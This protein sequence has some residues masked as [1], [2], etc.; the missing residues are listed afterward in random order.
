MLNLIEHLRARARA[1]AYAIQTVGASRSTVVDSYWGR[2]T[3]RSLRFRSADESLNYL[4]WRFKEYPLFQEFMELYG[5]HDGQTVLDYGCGPGNDLVGFLIYT[6][7]QKVIGYDVS[8]KALD[9]ARHRLALHQI[10]S[11]RVELIRSSDSIA[12]I[13]IHDRAVDYIYC[14]GVL[15]HTS[16]PETIL[17]EFYRI[18]K[19]GSQ[20][21]VMVY[22]RDS[23]W[24][25]LYTAYQKMIVENAFPGMDILQ[26]FSRNTDGEH[27]PIVRCYA[28]EDFTAMCKGLGFKV[29]YVGGYFASYELDLLNQLG[30]RATQDE[31]LAVEH[32][33]FLGAL[34]YDDRG[35]PL[36][37]G[38]HAGIGGVYK[39]YKA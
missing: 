14:E 35:Y 15:H 4:E 16:D 8:V 29:Q 32:K 6:K 12:D 2:H 13:P 22:N 34:V 25:H 18:L 31:R 1:K 11:D 23:L 33:E 36:Y 17:R 39:L 30:E 3:V 28:P 9:L 27:C 21:C 10:H 20:A 5:N 19:N 26:A 37:R 38:K 7:A 24:L